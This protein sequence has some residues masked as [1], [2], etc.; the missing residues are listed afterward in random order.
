MNAI[1][2]L[3]ARI[4]GVRAIGKTLDVGGGFQPYLGGLKHCVLE[5]VDPLLNVRFEDFET[6]ERFDFVLFVH[7]FEHLRQPFAALDKARN[8]LLPDGRI[9]L[10]VPNCSGWFNSARRW[11]ESPH[12]NLWDFNNFRFALEQRSFKIVEEFA[13][14]VKLPCLDLL[15]LMPVCVLLAR[16]LPKRVGFEMVFVVEAGGSK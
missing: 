12:Y 8:L 16:V 14:F 5:T 3:H 10:I 7:S 13:S 2:D 9:I 11:L 4:L 6:E 15:G 1:H